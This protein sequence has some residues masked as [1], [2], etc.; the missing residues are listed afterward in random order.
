MVWEWGNGQK[1]GMT[2]GQVI[3]FEGCEMTQQ[4]T[5]ACTS[6]AV[7]DISTKQ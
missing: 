2:K 3:N 4:G 7:R 6:Q 1:S 5:P